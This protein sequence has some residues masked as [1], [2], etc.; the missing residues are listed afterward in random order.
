MRNAKNFDLEFLREK[1]LCQYLMWKNAHYLGEMV[2][3]NNGHV[4]YL[5]VYRGFKWAAILLSLDYW[6]AIY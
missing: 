1:K 6:S 3:Y 2:L 5:S 4:P